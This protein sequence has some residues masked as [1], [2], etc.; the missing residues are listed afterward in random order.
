M[1]FL[2]FNKQLMR[3]QDFLERVIRRFIPPP[4]LYVCEA[5][6][7]GWFA[8]IGSVA[9]IFVNIAIKGLPG[10]DVMQSVFLV[11]EADSSPG[12]WSPLRLEMPYLCLNT[13][14]WVGGCILPVRRYRSRCRPGVWSSARRH[15]NS[16]LLASCG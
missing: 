12:S 1:N 3:K 8:E 7:S 6:E 14:G 10:M 15:C 13:G 2:G 4:I 11:S 16:A 5:E 9:V